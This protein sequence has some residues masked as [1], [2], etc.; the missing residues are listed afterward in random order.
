MTA[1]ISDPLAANPLPTYDPQR[2]HNLPEDSI[3]PFGLSRLVET[4][5]TAEL[6]TRISYDPIQQLNVTDDGHIAA[7]YLPHAGTVGTIMTQQDHQ[8]WPDKVED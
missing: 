8:E 4:S 5:P 1:V 7:F 6:P 3:L 2:P